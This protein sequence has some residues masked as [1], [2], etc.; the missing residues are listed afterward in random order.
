MWDG[1]RREPRYNI[2]VEA[3]ARVGDIVR[4]AVNVTNVSATGCRFVAPLRRLAM[5]TPVTLTIGRASVIDARVRWRIGDTHGLRFAH[6][7]QPAMLDHIRLFLSERPAY[8][9]ERDAMD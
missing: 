7:L 5:G 9:A 2:A 4:Q 6:P 1:V 3:D 8:V